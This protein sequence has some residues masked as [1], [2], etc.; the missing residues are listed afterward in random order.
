[1]AIIYIEILVI[2]LSSG[3]EQLVFKRW[4]VVIML[5]S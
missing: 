2:V 4:L 3:D 1:M 5:I